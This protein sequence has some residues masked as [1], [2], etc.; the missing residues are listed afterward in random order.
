[1]YQCRVSGGPGIPFRGGHVD[2]TGQ[3]LPVFPE[4]RWQYLEEHVAKLLVKASHRKKWLDWSHVR[5]NVTE[6]GST[7][8]YNQSGVVFVNDDTVLLGASSCISFRPNGITG[9]LKTP[10]ST[11]APKGY[12]FD[13]RAHI[14]DSN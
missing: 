7:Q 9:R 2:A 14:L 12:A 11:D 6:K 4:P 10:M 1:V 13:R 8:T 3:I 5:F